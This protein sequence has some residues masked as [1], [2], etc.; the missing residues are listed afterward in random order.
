MGGR[1]KNWQL[2][3]EA[4]IVIA[5]GVWL[6]VR[7]P[8]PPVNEPPEPTPEQIA[9]SRAVGDEIIARLIAFHDAENRYPLSLDE[10]AQS[11]GAPIPRPP[12][13]LNDWD[14]AAS[15]QAF[16]LAFC[17][18][19]DSSDTTMC[20]ASWWASGVGAWSFETI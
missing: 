3:L 2:I 20:I 1:R 4:L 12:A 6:W 14:Y 13:S 5:L 9:A 7:Y 15:G 11:D 17:V 16:R 18:L 19:T 8:P 10:L